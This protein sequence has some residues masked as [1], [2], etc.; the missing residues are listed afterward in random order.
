MQ[1][2]ICFLIYRTCFLRIFTC[3]DLSNW[4]L[5]SIASC[6]FFYH[7]LNTLLSIPSLL[8]QLT[9]NFVTTYLQILAFKPQSMLFCSLRHYRARSIE[10]RRRN[11]KKKND[12]S[13]FFYYKR[14]IHKLCYY[15]DVLHLFDWK[16]AIE[17]DGGV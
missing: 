16:S 2:L 17:H 7:S 14:C 5:L 3:L 11:N 9:I 10:E 1:I 4:T 6:T 13:R 12:K 15:S 8:D